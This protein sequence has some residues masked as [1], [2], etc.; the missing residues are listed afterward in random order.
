MEY[1]ALPQATRSF[2]S[3]FKAGT[4]PLQVYRKENT[5]VQTDMQSEDED[6]PDHVLISEEILMKTQNM[7]LAVNLMWEMEKM[8][9][10]NRFMGVFRSGR[11]VGA[12][13]KYVIIE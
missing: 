7:T 4:L 13:R 10:K 9:L 3:K 2:T 5:T 8:T 6:A 1:K 11:K 12:P